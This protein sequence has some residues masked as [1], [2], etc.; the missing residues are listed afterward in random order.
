MEGVFCFFVEKLGFCVF[1]LIWFEDCVYY[2][3][4]YYEQE[5]FCLV[6]FEFFCD[7]KS[8]FVFVKS[9]KQQKFFVKGVLE[10]IIDCCFYIFIGVDGKCVFMIN[11]FFNFFMIEVVEYGNC[12]FCVI[13][14]VS[15]D[16]VVKNFIL[17]NVKIIEQYV[18]FEQ[19]MIFFGFVGM[20]DFF[21]EEVF[22]F[23]CYCKEVGICV[24]VIIG[25]NCYIVESICCQIGVFGENENFIGKSYIGW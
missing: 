22:Q 25:D 2:V 16:D 19:N 3:S 1:Q 11:K 10:L 8:M 7:C 13:V 21:C 5:L 17:K 24:I 12:G 9:G 15:I 14:F 23:I 4:Y 6:I 20:F 18:V